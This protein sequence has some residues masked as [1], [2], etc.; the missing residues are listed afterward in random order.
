MTPHR[1]RWLLLYQAAA[2]LCDTITGALL[3]LA[4]ARTFRLMGLTIV[5]QPIGFVRFVG[6][7]VLCVGLSYLWAAAA[8]PIAEWR[9]QWRVTALIR[10]GVAFLLL[11]QVASGAMEH[12]WVAVILTDGILAAVQWI[13]LW[14]GSLQFAE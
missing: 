12:G 7:F 2:G 11:W 8:W 14:R 13:G 1:R 9:G 6:M 3:V 4:P 5:P 10:S